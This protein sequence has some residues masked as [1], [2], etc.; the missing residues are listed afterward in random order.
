M[1]DAESD[2]DKVLAK[3]AEAGAEITA[4]KGRT[5]SLSAD[6][7]QLVDQNAGLRSMN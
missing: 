3:L 5:A 6:V 2:R 4:E 1:R 7:A